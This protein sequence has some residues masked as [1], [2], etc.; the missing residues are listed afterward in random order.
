MDRSKGYLSGNLSLMDNQE[1]EGS[2]VTVLD[3]GGQIIARSGLALPSALT[4][5]ETRKGGRG[6]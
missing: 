6:P 2:K 4:L 5:Q 3:F 1:P